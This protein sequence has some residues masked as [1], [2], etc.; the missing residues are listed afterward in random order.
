MV[1]C[2]EEERD[3][4]PPVGAEQDVTELEQRAAN[5]EDDATFGGV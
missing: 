3:A 4:T 1:T 5:K 2:V